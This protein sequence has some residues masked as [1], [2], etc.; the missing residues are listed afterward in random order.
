MFEPHWPAG[1]WLKTLA[2]VEGNQVARDA[3]RLIAEAF[4]DAPRDFENWQAWLSGDEE[5]DPALV[6]V[7]Y[8][9][10]D[11]P[12]GV[13][14]CWAS[15]Y[16]KDLVVTPAARGQGI[17]EALALTVFAAFQARQ[18]PHVD[19]KTNLIANAA[20]ARLYRRLGMVEVDWGG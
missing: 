9:G 19:L 16:L 2:G 8:G 13:A 12:L 11:L 6:F 10:D 3:H 15:G 20:A 1:V 4:D 18:A 14:Q 5:Y 7:A 17:G